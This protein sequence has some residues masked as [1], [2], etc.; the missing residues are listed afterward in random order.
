MPDVFY[1]G[2]AGSLKQA[3]LVRLNG[4]RGRFAFQAYIAAAAQFFVAEE[5]AI[6]ASIAL[7]DELPGIDLLSNH[8]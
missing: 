7:P 3:S 4:W 1:P 5:S 8:S 2:Y 6:R